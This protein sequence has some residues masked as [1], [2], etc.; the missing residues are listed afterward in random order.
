MN[1]ALSLNFE[2]ENWPKMHI[3]CI[4]HHYQ[5]KNVSLRVYQNQRNHLSRRN[6]CRQN[7]TKFCNFTLTL[8]ESDCFLSDSGALFLFILEPFRPLFGIFNRFYQF[9]LYSFISLSRVISDFF[10]FEIWKK[11]IS[12]QSFLYLTLLIIQNTSPTQIR[13]LFLNIFILIF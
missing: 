10:L 2:L 7:F 12:N 3:F 4:F 13:K 11:S 9:H 5:S 8:T 6:L 1:F